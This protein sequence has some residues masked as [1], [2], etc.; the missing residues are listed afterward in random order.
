[1]TVSRKV[2]ELRI[3]REGQ[4]QHYFFLIFLSGCNEKKK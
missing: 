1:M 2:I 3:G 4:S